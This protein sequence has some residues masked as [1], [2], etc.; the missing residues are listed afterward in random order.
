[1]LC[2]NSFSQEKKEL[3]FNVKKPS[4]RDILII[5]N[6]TLLHNQP[7]AFKIKNK[8]LLIKYILE[9]DGGEIELKDNHVVLTPLVDNEVYLRFIDKTLNDEKSTEGVL[10]FYV[11]K[12]YKYTI[13]QGKYP[14]GE[15]PEDPWDMSDRLTNDEFSIRIISGHKKTIYKVV[16]FYV[17][18]QLEDRFQEFFIKGDCVPRDTSEY[19]EKANFFN[20]IYDRFNVVKIKEYNNGEI[21]TFDNEIELEHNIEPLVE[22]VANPNEH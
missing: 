1:M 6:D 22:V 5:D 17:T 21:K 10:R 11:F 15:N 9:F 19:I 8:S 2:A 12:N 14:Y 7:N 13:F 4:I 20:L 16:S 3:V 18:I